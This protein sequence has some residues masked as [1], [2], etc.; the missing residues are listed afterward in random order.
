MF[1]T[2]PT[3]TTQDRAHLRRLVRDPAT[4]FR[5]PTFVDDL[6]RRLAQGRTVDS[7]DVAESVVTMHS[8]VYVR[9]LDSGSARF[10]F[11]VYPDEADLRFGRLSV[12][13]QVGTALLGAR[14]GERLHVRGDRARGLRL[15]R[16]V[17]QPEATAA[18][19][20]CEEHAGSP[21]SELCWR[22]QLVA[23]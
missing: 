20:V 4:R 13:S 10:F 21:S 7:R 19:A 9:D 2:K 6:E 5:W 1:G 12:L 17:A 11:L 15:E 18:C 3:F 23:C 8:L 14:A 22:P 16:V